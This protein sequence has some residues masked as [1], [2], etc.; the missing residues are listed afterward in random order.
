MI[1]EPEVSIPLDTMLSQ[2]HPP[3]IPTGMPSWY[4]LDAGQVYLYLYYLINEDR[5][6]VKVSSTNYHRL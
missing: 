6:L 4:C 1:A 5:A 2:F 3:L